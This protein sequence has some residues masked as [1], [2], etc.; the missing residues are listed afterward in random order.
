MNKTIEF[1]KQNNHWYA[2]VP[3]HTLEEN[4]MVE[5]A[6]TLL[7]CLADGYPR[8]ALTISTEPD[9][10]TQIHLK[11]IE[12]NSCGATYILNSNPDA[13]IWLC[14]VTHDVINEHPE[15]IYISDINP[16]DTAKKQFFLQKYLVRSKKCCTFAPVLRK[17]PKQTYK[18]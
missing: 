6:D 17:E 7:E 18:L 12:H 5:G 10:E 4:E 11:M 16:Q 15:N 8:I 2:D 14:N 13:T 1:F 3:N 9:E